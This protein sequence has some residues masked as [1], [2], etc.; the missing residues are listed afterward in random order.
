MDSSRRTPAHLPASPGSEALK[1]TAQSGHMSE[2]KPQEVQASGLA[3]KGVPSSHT[4]IAST[5]Q[6]WLQMPHRLQ[7]VSEKTGSS[8][9]VMSVVV[10]TESL[11]I[12][13]LAG[14]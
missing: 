8:F 14:E 10:A 2:H 6:K 3:R 11:Y 7:R 1:H 13:G 9:L 12:S 4:P 5:G